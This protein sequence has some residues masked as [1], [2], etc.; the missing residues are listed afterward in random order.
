MFEY[1]MDRRKYIAQT[2]IFEDTG[3]SCYRMIWP[4]IELSRQR[5]DWAILNIDAQSK[6]R[7]A[8]LNACDLAVLFHP[9]DLEL[10]N[11]V[12]KRREKG[13]KTLVEFGDN[14]YASPAS[15][16]VSNEW[17]SP[18]VWQVYEIFLKNADGL[19]V[20]SPGLIELFKDKIRSDC[21]IH[22]IPNCLNDE[23]FEDKIHHQK[24]REDRKH[25]VL[26]WGGSLGHMADILSIK[27]LLHELAA[28]DENI[29]FYFM[30]NEAIPDMLELPQDRFR[31][32]PWGS[33][34]DYYAFLKELDLG[35]IPLNDTPY[36]QCRSDVKA[37]EMSA[38]GVVPILPNTLPYTTFLQ[39]T[40]LPSYRSLS[41]CKA[42]LLSYIRN[43]ELYLDLKQ[44]VK[45]YV[46]SYRR[47]SKDTT[48]AEV[49]ERYLHAN[50]LHVEEQS[51]LKMYMPGYQE[52]R[53]NLEAQSVP[54]RSVQK[55]L[56]LSTANAEKEALHLLMTT[57][58]EFQSID[59][60]LQLLVKIGRKER[61]EVNFPETYFENFLQEVMSLYA[62]D[63]R[64]LGVIILQKFPYY[65]EAWQKIVFL[66]KEGPEKYRDFYYDTVQKT[67]MHVLQSELIMKKNKNSLASEKKH[68]DPLPFV[69]EIILLY[70]TMIQVRFKL[71]EYYEE[72]KEYEKASKHF[73]ECIQLCKIVVKNQQQIKN[74]NFKFLDCKLESM[75]YLLKHR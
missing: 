57:W 7:A 31:F 51:C 6:R 54:A 55:A 23:I 4:A 39:K 65:E 32:F 33:V 19:I 17:S 29:L 12:R 40:Q 42:I 43:K 16:P 62:A 34:E 5:P 68:F 71:A 60:A 37:L 3:D 20:P 28:D 22:L 44:Q 70:D 25:W 61:F 26:G 21:N 30:G 63:V 56:T 67:L 10:L 48:R 8:I 36:N 46:Y 13:L 1:S 49:F 24:Y 35:I 2:V 45:E 72:I 53:D 74:I 75:K 14:F 38:F 73:E 52:I 66:L 47:A 9:H 18:H 59:A 58:K 69:E 50:N 11:V 27:S 64:V 15:S 41:E